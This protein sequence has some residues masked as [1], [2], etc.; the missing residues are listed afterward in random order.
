MHHPFLEI[1][2]KY[3]QA[4][5]EFD[6]AGMLTFV[7]PE[8]HYKVIHQ[9]KTGVHTTGKKEFERVSVKSLEYFRQREQYILS[10]VVKDNIIDLEIHFS[11][12]TAKELSNGM[13][14]GDRIDLRGK[15]EYIFKEGLIF[16]IID[17]T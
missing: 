2:K 9:G 16:S 5:N 4:Y 10:F 17:E 6:I 13:N 14:A 11:A 8:I 1:V 3:L 15:S 7:H 12:I